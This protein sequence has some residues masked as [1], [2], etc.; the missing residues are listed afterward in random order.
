MDP[1]LRDRIKVRCD[2]DVVARIDSATAGAGI[3]FRQQLEHIHP[4]VLEEHTPALS[5]FDVLPIDRSVP[6]HKR[7]FTRRML[8]ETGVA[9]WISDYSA[10][11]PMVGVGAVEESFNVR[12]CGNAYGWSVAEIEAASAEG[13]PLSSSLAMA[14]RRAVEQ[15][16]N[17][18]AFE[19]APEVGLYGL[20]D[21]PTFPRMLTTTT[22][23]SADTPADILAL[24]HSIANAT[25]IRTKGAGGRGQTMLMPLTPY[26]YIASTRLASDEATT[27][28]EAFLAE[29]PFVDSVVAVHELAGISAGSDMIVCAEMNVRIIGLVLPMMFTQYPAQFDNLAVKV[30]CRASCGGIASDYPL[31]VTTCVL[32]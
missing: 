16:Q 32:P 26:T 17:N 11:L 12:D 23:S 1:K 6:P 30:P 9:E 28:L 3:F 20:A 4:E 7:T 31:E 10:D 22:I 15:K 13:V 18:T 27:I 24:L 5:A 25:I 19:G 29:N 21:Y 14:A 8:N 2:D